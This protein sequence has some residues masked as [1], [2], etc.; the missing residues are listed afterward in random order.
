VVRFSSMH[1]ND[2]TT[3]R[4]KVKIDLRSEQKAK[5]WPRTMRK[6][7]EIDVMV[8]TSSPPP[9]WAYSLS[10]VQSARVISLPTSVIDTTLLLTSKGIIDITGNGIAVN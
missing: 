5:R 6:C 9:A 1:I 8:K 4:S 10:D 2:D 7:I 3:F